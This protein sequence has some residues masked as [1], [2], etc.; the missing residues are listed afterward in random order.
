M[1]FLGCAILEVYHPRD[2]L[3][4]HDNLHTF[5][6]P[7]CAL[8]AAV[9]LQLTPQP[10]VG[11]IAQ[12]AQS[13]INIYE[14]Q[15]EASTLRYIKYPRCG[16]CGCSARAPREPGPG[17]KRTRDDLG[18]KTIS[19]NEEWVSSILFLRASNHRLF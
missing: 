8:K 10:V 16:E 4:A 18:P 6:Y 3:V 7:L 9:N 5:V 12:R 14:M 19:G 2:A 13:E 1:Q 17:T 11:F 15:S